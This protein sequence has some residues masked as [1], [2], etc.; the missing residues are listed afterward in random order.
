[1]VVIAT[2]VAFNVVDHHM[3]N[4]TP[5]FYFWV[6]L[7]LFPCLFYFFQAHPENDDDGDDDGDNDDM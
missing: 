5:M 1:M 7:N 4:T 3:H 2:N 6:C